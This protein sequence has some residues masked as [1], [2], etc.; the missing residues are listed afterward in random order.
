MWNILQLEICS[1]LSVSTFKSKLSSFYSNK[2]WFFFMMSITHARGLL[3][4]DA[5]AFTILGFTLISLTH[6]LCIIGCC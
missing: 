1:C 3:P 6:N 2:I 4:V 5:M